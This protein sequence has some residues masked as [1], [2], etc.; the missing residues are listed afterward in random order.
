[1]RKHFILSICSF[2]KMTWDKEL[3]YEDVSNMDK[4]GFK[5]SLIPRTNHYYY[6]HGSSLQTEDQWIN[7]YV[8]QLNVCWFLMVFTLR[9][10]NA[11]LVS[12]Q[13][14][15]YE[16]PKVSVRV[17][18]EDLVTVK[19]RGFSRAVRECFLEDDADKSFTNIRQEPREKDSEPTLNNRN[20]NYRY[21]KYYKKA[22]QIQRENSTCEVDDTCFELPRR[23]IFRALKN[24]AEY[25]MLEMETGLLNIR[26]EYLAYRFPEWTYDG[27]S[28]LMK[29]TLKFAENHEFVFVPS[30]EGTY[31]PPK[32]FT[33]AIEECS[34][35]EMI[36]I[37]TFKEDF[38]LD[39]FVSSQLPGFFWESFEKKFCNRHNTNLYIQRMLKDFFSLC[40][41]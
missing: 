31:E 24:L 40:R 14:C 34:S 41:Y 8:I 11:H 10:V 25:T 13:N 17:F 36:R 4:A 15:Y 1:M 32:I 2:A 28:D 21:N 35:L 39:V 27:Y 22:V 29:M 12:F 3:W 6:T 18:S 9:S 37:H 26:S 16:I 38:N 23:S 20:Y 33:Q 19:M 5:N 7:N 30:Y